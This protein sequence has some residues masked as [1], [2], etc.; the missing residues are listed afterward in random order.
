MLLASGGISLVSEA[1][2]SSVQNATGGGTT[3]IAS[4]SAYSSGVTS[5]NGSGTGATFNILVG[6]T[7]ASSIS[8]FSAENSGSGY[9]IGDT[10]TIVENALGAGSTPITFT[11][12]NGITT[13]FVPED[14]IHSTAGPGGSLGGIGGTNNLSTLT[15]G[16]NTINSVQM[17]ILNGTLHESTE[18]PIE[19][20]DI[21]QIKYQINSHT[22]QKDAGGSIINI[23]YNSIFEFALI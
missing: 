2:L 19:N 1:L 20:N 23:N 18:V 12:T 13:N 22:G 14:I 4:D 9:K 3:L 8:S 6:G 10:I 5:T 11:I 21:I 17:A 16:S 7:S 15:T